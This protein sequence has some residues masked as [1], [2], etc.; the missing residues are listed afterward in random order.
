MDA[1]RMVSKIRHLTGSLYRGEP[2]RDLPRVAVA[3]AIREHRRM[4]PHVRPATSG[5]NAYR[6]LNPAASIP[7]RAEYIP[8]WPVDPA[9]FR[10]NPWN[11]RAS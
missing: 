8:H 1:R 6:M 4:C 7:T 11:R 10:W 3:R 2:N 9:N 5:S